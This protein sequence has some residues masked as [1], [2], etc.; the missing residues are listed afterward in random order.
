MGGMMTL[1][2]WRW[3]CGNDDGRCGIS[4]KGCRKEKE[5]FNEKLTFFTNFPKS[6]QL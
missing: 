6:R 5:G 1:I 2:S 4:R 3:L